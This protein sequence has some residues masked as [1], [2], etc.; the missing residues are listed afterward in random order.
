MQLQENYQYHYRGLMALRTDCIHGNNRCDKFICPCKC[1][2]CVKDEKDLVEYVHDVD[3]SHTCCFECDFCGREIDG[4]YHR[5]IVESEASLR[6]K[7]DKI[8][9]NVYQI[10]NTRTGDGDL[11]DDVMACFEESK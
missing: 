3:K 8:K 6:K 7:L 10:M 4:D 9:N 1:F 2:G 11:R 5:A